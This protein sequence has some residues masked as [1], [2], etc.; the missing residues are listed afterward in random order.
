LQTVAEAKGITVDREWFLHLPLRGQMAGVALADLVSRIIGLAQHFKVSVIV[1]DP[2]YK[3][4]T[5]GDENS[6]RDQTVFFNQLDR[7]TT[8]A[9]CTVIMND[10]FSKG[11]QSEKDPLDA[12]RGS[13][14]KGGDVDAAM[15][16]RKHEV[17]SCYRV[18]LIHRELPPVES[19]VIGWKFPLMEL[20]PD[21]NPESMKKVKG[22]QPKK[23][24]PLDLLE[25]I[26]DTTT[27][28]PVSIAKWA[29]SAR[30]SRQ[31]LQGYLDGMRAK[32]WI[33]TAGAGN[34]ARQ[35]VSPKGKE[36]LKERGNA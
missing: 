18:D 1:L 29:A 19:F 21:L 14:A 23:H 32:G 26:K 13:S 33:L 28:S 31:T 34:T 6:S 17:E 20:R 3:M 8:E 15:V 22:G 2:I 5:E 7:L 4:N 27:E 25:A 16:L 10:H 30:V 36:A 35:Y 12:I 24:D 11:N 9:G